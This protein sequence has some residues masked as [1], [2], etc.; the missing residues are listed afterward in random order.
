MTVVEGY[1]GI[2]RKFHPRCFHAVVRIRS[3]PPNSALVLFRIPNPPFSGKNRIGGILKPDMTRA[4]SQ[5]ICQ[6]DDRSVKI[7]MPGGCVNPC[8]IMMFS[9]GA[10]F[11]LLAYC[12]ESDTDPQVHGTDQGDDPDTPRDHCFR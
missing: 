3:P 8:I 12:E 10:R 5:A 7:I 1:T 4:R 2:D 11:A 6:F 9:H